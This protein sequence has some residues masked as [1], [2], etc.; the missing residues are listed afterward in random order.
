MSVKVPKWCKRPRDCVRCTDV[1][2]AQ[3]S[4][5]QR[6]QLLN[7]R[8]ACMLD[9]QMIL[10]VSP[11]QRMCGVMNEAPSECVV[12]WMK[13][14]D[15]ECVVWWMK[16]Q[17]CDER[18]SKSIPIS[19]THEHLRHTLASNRQLLT[20]SLS[21]MSPYSCLSLM[22][23]T[24]VTIL[25]SPSSSR[26]NLLI[27]GWVCTRRMWYWSMK[28]LI[29]YQASH[30][31]MSYSSISKSRLYM[32]MSCRCTHIHAFKSSRQGVA[33]LQQSSQGSDNR[34]D[35]LCVHMLDVRTHINIDILPPVSSIRVHLWNS[36]WAWG[37]NSVWVRMR[38]S[39]EWV[40]NARVPRAH[41]WRECRALQHQGKC[42]F[43][44][45]RIKIVCLHVTYMYMHT[46]I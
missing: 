8:P 42:H 13:L 40:P 3:M 27:K 38:M 7:E 12:W 28:H 16:L 4:W 46:R 43:S 24:H 23:I 26:D 20:H 29:S 35:I 15:S 18:S 25:M 31:R 5:M 6:M 21:L 32:F 34:V 14:Q 10:N 44:G 11:R 9:A 37:E 45:N 17:V 22:S 30:T 33:G 39:T 2:D 19:H 36:K 41:Q 1:L